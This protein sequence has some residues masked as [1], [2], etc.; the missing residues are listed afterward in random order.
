MGH[1]LSETISILLLMVNDVL[2]EICSTKTLKVFL[3][4]LLQCNDKAKGLP[5]YFLHASS[6]SPAMTSGNSG[7]SRH[8]AEKIAFIMIHFY[9]HSPLF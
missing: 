6:C 9:F 7:L 5:S 1:F 4:T 2:A 8:R 3:N